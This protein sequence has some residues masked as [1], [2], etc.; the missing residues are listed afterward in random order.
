MALSALGT[1]GTCSGKNP[2]PGCFCGCLPEDRVRTAQG[3]PGKRDF[4]EKNQ[5][6]PGKVKEF[7]D[8]FYNL[9]EN[10]GKFILP[11]ISDQIGGTLRINEASK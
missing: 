11:N 5:G 10:S 4:L 2:A 6:K 1:V 9:R 7:S 8:H 3:K